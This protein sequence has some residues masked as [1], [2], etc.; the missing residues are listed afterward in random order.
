M[1]TLGILRPTP[2]R[3]SAAQSG[4]SLLELLV[5]IAIMGI[6]AAMAAPNVQAMIERQRNVE[7]SQTLLAAFRDARTESLLRRQVVTVEV[8]A[9][10]IRLATP[11]TSADFVANPNAPSSCRSV[12]NN[13]SGSPNTSTKCLL[14]KNASFPVKTSVQNP[15]TIYFLPNKKVEFQGNANVYK[16]QTIC[17]TEN[18]KSGRTVEVDSNGN[19]KIA[20]EVSQC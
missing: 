20:G 17:N 5:V 10:Q 8:T 19:A 12:G 14:L 6:L 15:V 3:Q 2:H 16:Y 13:A 1:Q 9:N 18:Q 4:F 11:A 7:L